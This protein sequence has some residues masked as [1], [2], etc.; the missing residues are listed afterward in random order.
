[1]TEL[2]QTPGGGETKGLGMGTV[3]IEKTPGTEN[4]KGI[5]HKLA[6]ASKEIGAVGKWGQ[7]QH[8]RYNFRGIEHVINAVH[9]VFSRLGIVIKVKVLDWKYEV[10]TTSKGAGQIRVRLLVEYTFI[11]GESGDELSVTVPAEAFDTSDKATSKAISV[12]LRTALTQVLY[13]PTAEVD[14]DYS[15]ITVDGVDHS[16][17]DS[18][19]DKPEDLSEEFITRVMGITDLE[20]LRNDYMNLAQDLREDPR[21]MRLYSDCKNRLEGKDDAG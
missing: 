6:L 11:D 9:P 2:T 8:Q 1:M 3:A 7:N 10:A 4:A 20:A 21:V 17:V 5:A 16:E 13:I 19:P 12:A 18:K 14:R 15:H